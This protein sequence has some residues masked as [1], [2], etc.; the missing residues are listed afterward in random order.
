MLCAYLG[1]PKTLAH[2]RVGLGKTFG[3]IYE[4]ITDKCKEP[5]CD[6]GRS[7]IIGDGCRLISLA[8]QDVE[9]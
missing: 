6:Q 1:S 2:V 8:C 5:S 3:C 4:T 7:Y 9:P